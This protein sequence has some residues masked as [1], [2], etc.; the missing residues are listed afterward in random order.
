MLRT[1]SFHVVGLSHHTAGVATRER[2]S[3]SPVEIAEILA[4]EGRAGRSGVL[5]STCN[6]CEFYWTGERDGARW[7]TELARTRLAGSLPALRT[8]S[9]EAAA[10]HLFVVASGLDSQIVGEVEILGQVRRACELARAAGASTP[11]LEA[12]FAAAIRAGRRV[13]RETPLGQHPRSVSAAAIALAVRQ[14]G[15]LDGRTAV[16]LGAGEV[17]A[18]ALRVLRGEGAG[19]VVVVNRRLERARAL[20]GESGARTAPWEELDREVGRADLVV[21][22]TA[23]RHPVL[24]AAH[25]S[26]ALAV[27]A[28]N[29]RGLWVLDLAVPR[30][31][32]SAVRDLP[33]VRLYDLDDLQERCCPAEPEAPAL[34]EARRIVET[35]LQHLAGTLRGRAQSG[36]LARLHRMGEQVVEEETARLLDQLGSLTDAERQAVRSMAERVARRL[37]Y[38]MSRA[39]R[40]GEASE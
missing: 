5:L 3:L 17:A 36:R 6:R 25:V 29:G 35:E 14:L 32:D 38:P 4:G 18:G 30:N 23:A 26:Q 19:D 28:R 39:V 9:G 10:R 20:A 21:V 12:I 22:A 33:G 15:T 11:E 27:S 1:L 34:V 16:I 40:M 8:L 7:F 37:L 13:R 31:V 24:T 2:L